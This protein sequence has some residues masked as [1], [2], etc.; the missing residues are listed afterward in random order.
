MKITQ[1]FTTPD[2]ATWREWLAEHGTT[3]SE[4]WLVYYK[5]STGK[6]TISYEDSLEEAQCF[7]HGEFISREILGQRPGRINYSFSCIQCASTGR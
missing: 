6:A 5:A 2:R 7:G 1:T 3:E 4:V